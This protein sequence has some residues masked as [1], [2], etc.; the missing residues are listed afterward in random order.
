MKKKNIFLS[1]LCSVMGCILLAMAIRGIW[2]ERTA[3]QEYE[4]LLT[5]ETKTTVATEHVTTTEQTETETLTENTTFQTREDLDFTALQERN[6]DIYAWIEVPGTNIDYPIVQHPTDNA[7]Y[8]THTI[9]HSKTTAAAIYTENYNQKDFEDHHTVIYG[10][11]MKNGSMFKTLHN[12]EDYD[13]FQEHRDVIIYMPDQTRY[14]QIFAAYTYDNRHLLYNYDCE[15]AEEFQSY[16]DTEIFSNKD[17]GA[18]ID[19]DIEVTA[20]DHIITLSTCVN[21]GDS[22]RR[23]LV[24]A[25]LVSIDQ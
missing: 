16:L 3:G 5:K 17:F 4:T 8:L 10:H 14:Y 6:A 20:E 12:F 13:F 15:D 1:V 21:S 24:Q 9:D 7:Y 11:N 22:K 18:Y 25:V 23:Y 2:Q 19:H